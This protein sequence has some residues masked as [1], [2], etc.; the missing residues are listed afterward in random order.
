[1]LTASM[2]SFRGAWINIV[3]KQ[4]WHFHFNLKLNS[5][6]KPT[7]FPTHRNMDKCFSLHIRIRLQL[8]VFKKKNPLR[9]FIFCVNGIVAR[10]PKT[11]RSFASLRIYSNPFDRVERGGFPS[12]FPSLFF[13][14]SMQVLWNTGRPL[15]LTDSCTDCISAVCVHLPALLN[16]HSG[17]QPSGTEMDS[18]WIQQVIAA[19]LFRTSR[20]SS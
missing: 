18:S 10:Q 15:F 13:S 7:R 16:C 1:M 17:C 14:H 8:L 11:K 20:G 12:L 6:L 9:F 3:T 5:H 19:H 4:M 2:L